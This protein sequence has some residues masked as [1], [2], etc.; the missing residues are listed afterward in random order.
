M[1][2]KR[3]LRYASSSYSIFKKEL[4]RD[5][6]L[7]LDGALSLLG[8]FD[9]LP[10]LE[11]LDSLRQTGKSGDGGRQIVSFVRNPLQ[12]SNLFGQL[13]LAIANRQ[14]VSLTYRKFESN[15]KDLIISLYPYLLKEYNRRWFLFAGRGA[16]GKLLCFALDRIKKVEPLPA[17]K[18]KE[19]EGDINEEFDDIIGVTINPNRSLDR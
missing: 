14:T 13:F 19:Y 9:G 6:E 17:Q 1:R 4:N 15:G 12:R 11:S 3:C 18:Y 5:E 16:D 2:S 10:G 7:L 8:Q